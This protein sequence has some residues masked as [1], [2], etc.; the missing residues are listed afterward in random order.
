LAVLIHRLFNY[1]SEAL[2]RPREEKEE[3]R[4]GQSW[5]RQQDILEEASSPSGA[6]CALKRVEE[7]GLYLWRYMLSSWS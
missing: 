5:E 7:S 3:H 4:C 6:L 2:K 1:W